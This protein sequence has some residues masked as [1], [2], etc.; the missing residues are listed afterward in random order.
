MEPK[1][2]YSFQVLRI[3]LMAKTYL[4]TSQQLVAHMT[5]VRNFFLLMVDY[6]Q[7]FKIN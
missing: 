5:C 7:L 1:M 2:L 6:K 3:H 4:L